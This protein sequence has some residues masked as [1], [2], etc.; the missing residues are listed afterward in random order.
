[1]ATVTVI[2]CENICDFSW[3]KNHRKGGRWFVAY[4]LI[5]KY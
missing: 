4:I 5:E 2:G 1:M 3:Q